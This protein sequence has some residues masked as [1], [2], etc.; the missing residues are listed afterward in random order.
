[1]VETRNIEHVKRTGKGR[2][3]RYK[4]TQL[5]F[6]RLTSYEQTDDILI[7]RDPTKP[8][9]S[10]DDTSAF[11]WLVQG[12]EGQ[13]RVTAH[14]SEMD[15][16]LYMAFMLKGR[17]IAVWYNAASMGSIC[18]AFPGDDEDYLEKDPFWPYGD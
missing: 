7:G 14:E 6:S 3:T 11:D 4:R 10:S 12:E 8:G 1:M 5:T 16:H 2:G 13:H 18:T 17:C 9:H 15:G